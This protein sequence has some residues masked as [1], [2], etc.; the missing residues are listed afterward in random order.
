MD[1]LDMIPPYVIHSILWSPDTR[2]DMDT[3]LHRYI[4]TGKFQKSRYDT[5]EIR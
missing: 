3:I 1:N 2:Y 4:D 5:A